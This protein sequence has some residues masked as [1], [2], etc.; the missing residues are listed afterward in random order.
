M[1]T[2]ACQYGTKN[3]MEQK[4][5]LKKTYT[6]LEIIAETKGAYGHEKFRSVC[7]GVA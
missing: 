2:G 4:G 5:K 3:F 7:G 6:L 1:V